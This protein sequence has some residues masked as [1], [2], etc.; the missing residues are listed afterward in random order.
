MRDRGIASLRGYQRGGSTDPDQEEKR[1]RLLQLMAE[2]R[3][4][5]RAP[6]RPDYT[7][8]LPFSRPDTLMGDERGDMMR[9]LNRFGADTTQVSQEG[10]SDFFQGD[11]YGDVMGLVSQIREQYN[12]ARPSGS[13]YRLPSQRV[14]SVATH[15]DKNYRITG[16]YWGGGAATRDVI[17]D[18][19]IIHGSPRKGHYVMEDDGKKVFRSGWEPSLS[20]EEIASLTPQERSLYERGVDSIRLN[21]VSSLQG[22]HG[23]G[24]AN[25]WTR[26][27]T[28]RGWEEGPEESLRETLAHEL[29]HSLGHGEQ[30]S[31]DFAAVVQAVRGASPNASFE[32][33][34]EA[35]RKTYWATLNEYKYERMGQSS[36]GQG[37][38]TYED[39]I[40]VD[41]NSVR[42]M[43][44]QQRSEMRPFL[45]EI[46]ATPA[47]AGHPINV[48]EA[49]RIELERLN[50]RG[51]LEK[52]SDK[53]RQG[54]GSLRR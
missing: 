25:Y 50:N 52:L 41:P 39:P 14:P 5:R 30:S 54:I 32:D 9:T 20:P 11:E 35:A 45:E 49:E 22:Q 6:W 23:R 1:R 28:E 31:D 36:R 27:M 37:I 8:G 21:I 4:E 29:G 18:G 24:P 44:E 48:R 43:A 13:S 2:A 51:L 3:A 16:D 15:G 17:P 7:E 26:G 46:L 10:I 19:S 34:L 33:V 47:Y 53:V 40:V 42:G 12:D 38:G